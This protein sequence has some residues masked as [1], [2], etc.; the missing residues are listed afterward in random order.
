MDVYDR[1]LQYDDWATRELFAASSSLTEEQLDQEFDIGHRTVRATF[2]HMITTT[3][4]WMIEMGG[5]PG[6]SPP[7]GDSS[8]AALGVRFNGAHEAFSVYVRSL[9]D[10]ERL[11]ERFVD[12]F[13]ASITQIGA[14]LHVLMH[15][16]EHRS[17][18]L[19]L[20]QRLAIPDVP[21]IDLALWEIQRIEAAE[22]TTR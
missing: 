5:Q 7:G 22:T 6:G 15:N 8:L 12:D 19:H 9:R 10:A 11:D 2:D 4:G 17:E 13:G 3:Q 1:L 20:L 21:E 16:E 14:A 18:I